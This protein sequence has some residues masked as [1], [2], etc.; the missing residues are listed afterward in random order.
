M[1]YAKVVVGLPVQGPFDYAAS[2]AISRKIKDGSRV[3][4]NF[5][6][7]KLIGYVVGLTKQSQVPKIKPILELIDEGHL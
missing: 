6:G 3:L 2:L 5:A 7:R 4:I 1:L